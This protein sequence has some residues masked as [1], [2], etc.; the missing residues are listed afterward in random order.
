M[1]LAKMNIKWSISQEKTLRWI[2][3][4]KV[5]QET[6]DIKKNLNYMT[7]IHDTW[8]HWSAQTRS[9]ELFGVALELSGGV[10]RVCFRLSFKAKETR[11]LVDFW[12]SDER[13]PQS[14]LLARWCSPMVAGD[15]TERLSRGLGWRK[16]RLSELS[17]EAPEQCLES[18]PSMVGYHG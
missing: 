15:L 11:N 10:L 5:G 12:C 18:D 7:Q 17:E 8:E 16:Y 13:G 14:F 2:K 4:L 9:L 1:D 3:T 6:K